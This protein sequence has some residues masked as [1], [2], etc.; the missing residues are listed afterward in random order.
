MAFS[1]EAGHRRRCDQQASHRYLE[2]PYLDYSCETS[3]R[4][5]RLPISFSRYE[6]ILPP[7]RSPSPMALN[8]TAFMINELRAIIYDI[9]VKHF[10][11]QFIFRYRSRGKH[12]PKFVRQCADL[13]K[14]TR[15]DGICCIAGPSSGNMR[16]MADARR[17]GK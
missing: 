8:I 1:R 3:Y 7:Q 4:T 15:G 9:I 12:T 13:A 16:P 6:M 2:Y 11:G 5:I 17:T 14:T 10:I